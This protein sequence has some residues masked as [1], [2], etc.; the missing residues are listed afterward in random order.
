MAACEWVVD[1]H[2][3]CDPWWVPGEPRNAEWE[4][5]TPCRAVDPATS[6]RACRQRREDDDCINYENVLA[7]LFILTQLRD[8]F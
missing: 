4:Y 1:H 5:A 3:R 7:G 8:L 6:A 2:R